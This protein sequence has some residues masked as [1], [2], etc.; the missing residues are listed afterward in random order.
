MMPVLNERLRPPSVRELSFNCPHC[1]ALAKQFWH[2]ILAE[3]LADTRIPIRFTP[4]EAEEF[5]KGIEERDAAEKMTQWARRVATGLPFMDSTSRDPY[6]HAVYNASVSQCY[7]CDEISIWIG[8]KIVWPAAGTVAPPNSDLNLDIKRDYEEAAAIVD[9]SP[10]GAA[11]LLRLAIQ[12]ICVEL[13]GAGRNLNEDIATLVVNGLDPR[14]QQALDVVRVTGNNAVHPGEMDLRDDRASAER[15]FELVNLIAEIMISQ[16][17][18]VATMF[19]GLPEGAKRGIE[20][21]D[22]QQ[23]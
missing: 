13:G 20:Q 9:A 12:K 17:R 16:P 5:G 19:D 11:A 8:D 14:V 7:N 23:S 4:E 2:S 10:R 3:R 21:R 6:A 1:G 22:K 15:L 18:H